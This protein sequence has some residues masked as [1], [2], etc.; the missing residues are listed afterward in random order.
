M[1]ETIHDRAVATAQDLPGLV[2]NLEKLD[3]NGTLL[4]QIVGNGLATSKTVWGGLAILVLTQV[5]AK[6][7]LGW[8][9]DFI[10]IL[11]GLGAIAWL[12]IKTLGPITGL[13]TPK[14]PGA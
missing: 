1:P 14:K 12:R 11:I 6:Y 13:L 9:P 3:P 5:S 8:G 2:A 10:T 7:N 4:Q